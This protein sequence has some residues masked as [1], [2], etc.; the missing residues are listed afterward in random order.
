MLCRRTFRNLIVSIVSAVG[1]LTAPAFA[2][3]E[4]YG[5]VNLLKT[6]KTPFSFASRSSGGDDHD[7]LQPLSLQSRLNRTLASRLLPPRLYLPGRMVLGEPAEFIIKGR[8]GSWAALAMADRDSGASPIQGHEIH[9]GADRKLVSLGQ[10]PEGGVLS[11]V[12]DT[13]IQGDLIGQQLYF[14]AVVWSKPDFSDLEV[15]APVPSEKEGDGANVIVQPL[16]KQTSDKKTSTAATAA[17]GSAATNVLPSTPPK[18]NGVTVAAET[19]HK[20]GIRIV[21]D[22]MVPVQSLHANSSAIDSGRP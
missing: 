18:L 22:G 21:P 13:P 14:E 7:Q 11:L 16:A 20:R 4:V 19:E 3:D 15:A 12:I 10:I 9:L 2:A 5:P 6:M 1:L 17:A 8:P